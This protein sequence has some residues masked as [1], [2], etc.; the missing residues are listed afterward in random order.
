[1]IISLKHAFVKSLGA[2]VITMSLST[3]YT[4]WAIS[5]RADFIDQVEW[6]KSFG[7]LTPAGKM[8]I[9]QLWRIFTGPLLHLDIY[10]LCGNGLLLWFTYLILFS[11]EDVQLSLNLNIQ[12]QSLTRLS[13]FLGSIVYLMAAL[14]SVLRVLIGVDSWSI[15]LSGATLA[16]LSW[17]TISLVMSPLTQSWSI[18]SAL[19]I[20]PWVIAFNDFSSEVDITSHLIGVVLG[21]FCAGA[22]CFRAAILNSASEPKDL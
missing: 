9:Y 5:H 2:M 13:L 4:A 11:Q 3:L 20:A 19:F 15:G 14:I 12:H 7:A 1:M 6:A 16:F 22:L 18:K 17:V 10:H 21:S 8:S